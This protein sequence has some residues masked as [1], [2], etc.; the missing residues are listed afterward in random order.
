MPYKNIED[1]N[2]WN[3]EYQRRRSAAERHTRVELEATIIATV[4]QE[5][6]RHDVLSL[7]ERLRAD[8]YPVKMVARAANDLL[9]V[10][11]LLWDWRAIPSRLVLSEEPDNPFARTS[12]QAADEAQ[13]ASP[14][15]LLRASHGATD[16]RR[17]A[18]RDTL[19]ESE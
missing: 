11:I 17:G 9:R 2:A 10:G 18:I 16:T 6:G 3:R 15:P 14:E 5:P 7:Y 4:R 13:L 1:Y 8:N 12:H 19:G